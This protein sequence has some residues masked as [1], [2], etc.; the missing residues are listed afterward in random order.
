MKKST[1]AGFTLLEVLAVVTMIGVLAAIAVP[2]WVAFL[3]RQRLN[4]ANNQVYQAMRQAQSQARQNRETW[5]AS[6]RTYNGTVQWA[7]HSADRIKIPLAKIP[8]Q[9]F[10]GEKIGTS[11]QII[12]GTNGT[13]LLNPDGFYQILFNH[14]G[15]PISSNGNTCTSSG[16]NF[17]SSVTPTQKSPRIILAKKDG[18]LVRRCVI[19]KTPLGA[20]SSAQDEICIQ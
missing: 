8:W 15:C 18:S 2:S 3:D 6:F 10:S 11:I 9:N 19:L 1:S 17:P 14:K 5:Q 13:N 7:I 12:T 16:L 4:S 20:M